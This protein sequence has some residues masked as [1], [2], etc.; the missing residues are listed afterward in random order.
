MTVAG[1][2][3][4]LPTNVR[5]PTEPAV[6]KARAARTATRQQRLIPSA[7]GMGAGR[8]TR[9]IIIAAWEGK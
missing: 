8:S 5:K 1:C 2:A 6:L 7:P 4:R 9:G 3:M